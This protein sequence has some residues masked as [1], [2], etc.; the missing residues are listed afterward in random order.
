MVESI[1]QQSQELDKALQELQAA[2]E[3]GAGGKKKGS[4][5]QNQQILEWSRMNQQCRTL[6]ESYKLELRQVPSEEKGEYVRR[7]DDFAKRQKALQTELGWKKGEAQRSQLIP[8]DRV[9][10]GDE[11]L[12]DLKT[13]Q[14]VELGDR[15][16]KKTGESLSRTKKMALEAEQ[17]GVTTLEKLNA[18]QEQISR[19]NE[20]MDDV[21][22]NLDRSKKLLGQIARNAA[23]DR[24]IQILCLLVTI[25]IIACVT[26]AAVGEDGGKLNVPD[27]VRQ[28]APT[29][30]SS[31]SSGGGGGKLLRMLSSSTPYGN[32]P[33]GR[34]LRQDHA[35]PDAG[36][37]LQSWFPA[38]QASSGAFFWEA[39]S[40]SAVETTNYEMIEP[41]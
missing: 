41:K 16:N 15:L 27:R 35:Q 11:E 2:M 32:N 25:T 39:P 7:L 37:D 18:Q 38:E 1:E 23:S 5:S 12:G 33:R 26:L 3:A 31:Q 34:G 6:L 13:Q 30:S 14:L 9:A 24:C 40:R 8:K 22:H 19:V 21:Q 29:T 17:I 36:L 20:D 4:T 28:K 10:A